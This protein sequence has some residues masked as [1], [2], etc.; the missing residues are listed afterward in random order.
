VL[1]IPSS[2]GFP[3][4]PVRHQ[5]P[6]CQFLFSAFFY[7]RFLLNEIFSELDETKAEVPILLTRRRSPKGRRRRAGRQPH[8]RMARAHLWLRH[9]MVL[10]PRAPTDIALPPIYCLQRE[11]PKESSIDPRKVCSAAAIED[12]FRGTKVSVP[13]PCRDGEPS[14][15]TPEPSP[16]TPPPSPSPLLTPMMR[17]E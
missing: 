14:P 17:R 11:N 6:K 4:G 15:S 3:T 9:H 2:W 7:S 13:V 12:Q 1:I 16:S 10:A 8:H 5:M